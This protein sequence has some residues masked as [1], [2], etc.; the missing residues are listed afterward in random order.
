MRFPMMLKG[1]VAAKRSQPFRHI[2]FAPRDGTLIEVRHGPDQGI[3][4]A[5]WAGQ[6]QAFVRDDDPLRRTLNRVSLWRPAKPRGQGGRGPVTVADL[7]RPIER[8]IQPPPEPP[9]IVAAAEA[10]AAT[11]L[12]SAIVRPRRKSQ[13]VP[14]KVIVTPRK[15]IRGW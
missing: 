7:V 13:P 2:V 3:V 12:P 15:K 9:P 5:P 6:N 14:A 11:T 8:L 10:S 1:S 4:L